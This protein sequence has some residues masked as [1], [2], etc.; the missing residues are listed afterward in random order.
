[1]C[2]PDKYRVLIQKYAM[3]TAR[4]F[5]HPTR[6]PLSGTR[7]M[8]LPS[9][10][11]KFRRRVPCSPMCLPTI[12]GPLTFELKS[13]PSSSQS[14]WWQ[15]QSAEERRNSLCKGRGHYTEKRRGR[16]RWVRAFSWLFCID[17]QERWRLSVSDF[18]SYSASFSWECA[19]GGAILGPPHKLKCLTSVWKAGAGWPD[20]WQE[21]RCQHGIRK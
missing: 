11:S 13:R 1:V 21:S 18:V 4:R 3:L 17:S 9:L 6:P 10:Y 14:R 15:R 5:A 2:Y 12:A 20:F 8:K 16:K 7:Q 19:F